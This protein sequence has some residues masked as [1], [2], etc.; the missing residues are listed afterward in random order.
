MTGARAIRVLDDPESLARFAADWLSDRLT[1]SAG[2]P[3]VALAGGSTPKRLYQLLAEPGYDSRIP[4]ERTHW[5]WGDERMVPADDPRSNQRMV[6]E[7]LLDP[8]GIA[9]TLVHAVD[10]AL[11][12]ESAASAYD[13]ALRAFHGAGPVTAETPLFTVTLLGLGPDGHTASLFPG[14]PGLAERDRWTTTAPGGST[15]SPNVD[16]VTLSYP[17]IAASGDVAF[18]VAGADKRAMVSRVLAGDPILPASHVTA[19]GRVWWLLD[20]AAAPDGLE[21]VSP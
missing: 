2:A 7:A 1:Q 10:T 17:A 11:D 8:R 18:L 6:R 9:S 16:R 4:W 13:H 21:D 20:R 12:V 3:A 14:T 5:F 19:M 15:L